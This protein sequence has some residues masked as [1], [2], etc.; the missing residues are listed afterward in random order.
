MGEKGVS[1]GILL[2][3]PTP[4]F[5]YLIEYWLSIVTYKTF[6]L[7]FPSNI[8]LRDLSTSFW[9]SFMQWLIPIS[10]DPDSCHPLV[11]R[12]GPAASGTEPLLSLLL[13]SKAYLTNILFS[14]QNFNHYRQV[15]RVRELRDLARL[16]ILTDLQ[17][18]A[19][20][21]LFSLKPKDS[22][23][24]GYYMLL[25]KRRKRKLTSVLC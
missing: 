14:F 19:L 3:A 22:S 23:T 5:W 20:V 16:T 13:Q 9:S 12:S 7:P 18:Q 15:R 17:V 4:N 2:L 1:L 21:F 10:S 24:L 11:I 6:V 8:I 25:W